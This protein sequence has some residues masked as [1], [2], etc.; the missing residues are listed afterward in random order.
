MPCSSPVGVSWGVG[1]DDRGWGSTATAESLSG[2]GASALGGREEELGVLRVEGGGGEGAPPRAAA[3]AAWRSF[4][5]RLSSAPRLELRGRRDEEGGERLVGRLLWDPP[6]PPAKCFLPLE[7]EEEKGRGERVLERAE[8]R[9]M[10]LV[11]E[12]LRLP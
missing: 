1:A 12:D 10:G 8:R 11:L 6:P 7:R 3:T 2:W 5:L 9:D 4:F